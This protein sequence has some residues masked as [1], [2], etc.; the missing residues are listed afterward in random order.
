M[1]QT[2][3]IISF[4]IL[5]PGSS[6]IDLPCDSEYKVDPSMYLF[7]TQGLPLLQEESLSWYCCHFIGSRT[8]LIIPMFMLCPSFL[9]DL[10][11]GGWR[12]KAIAWRWNLG[13]GGVGASEEQK[14][15]MQNSVASSVKAPCKFKRQERSPESL[16]ANHTC[17]YIYIYTHTSIKQR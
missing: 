15:G 11:E 5:R 12:W 7:L 4:Y 14:E 1:R 9:R 10:G 3:K 2:Q 13:D 17:E 16:T 6:S 8:I